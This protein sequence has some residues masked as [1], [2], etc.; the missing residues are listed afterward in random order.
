MLNKGLFNQGIQT[1]C[2][3]QVGRPGGAGEGGR[4]LP[5]PPSRYSSFYIFKNPMIYQIYD[6]MMGIGT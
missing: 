3:S 4:H 2:F 5:L 6:V 1:L